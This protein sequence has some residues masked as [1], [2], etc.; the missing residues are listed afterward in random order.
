MKAL[1]LI[2]SIFVITL[3]ACTI[4]PKEAPENAGPAVDSTTNK[5]DTNSSYMPVAAFVQED[6]RR[7]DSFYA[8][9]LKKST[10]EGKKDSAYIQNADFHILAQSFLDKALDS[11][12]FREGFTETPLMDQ[13]TQQMNFIYNAKKDTQA[14]RKVIVYISPSINGD[15]VDRV[16][17]EKKYFHGDTTIDQKLS[18]RMKHYFYILTMLEPKKGKPV[19]KVDKVI[20]E[21]QD[22][23]NE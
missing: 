5:V 20:W 4:K 17:M 22:F 8:G 1:Q 11:A 9:I 3:T 21:P 10:K 13:T 2:I 23:T 12:S 6:I 19:T 15:K 18:W 16:Y 14:L 7:V